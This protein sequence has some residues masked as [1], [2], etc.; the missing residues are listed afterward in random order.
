MAEA[1]SERFDPGRRGAAATMTGWICR[2][3]SNGQHHRCETEVRGLYCTCIEG[4]CGVV[5]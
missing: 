1:E 3:C 2:S 5:S 4:E